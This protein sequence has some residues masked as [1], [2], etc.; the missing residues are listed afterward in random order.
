M[1]HQLILL[2][3]I[4]PLLCLGQ[5]NDI[6]D[7]ISVPQNHDH[8]ATVQFSAR[9]LHLTDIFHLTLSSS[10]HGEGWGTHQFI[11]NFMRVGYIETDA[12]LWMNK[13]LF[14][15]FTIGIGGLYHRLETEERSIKRINT[16]IELIYQPKAEL[17]VLFAAQNFFTS[18]NDL[19]AASMPSMRWR[20]FFRPEPNLN[21]GLTI[22]THSKTNIELLSQCFFRLSDN[23]TVLLYTRAMPLHFGFGIC[24]SIGPHIQIETGSDYH[25]RLGPSPYF[26]IRNDWS[27]RRIS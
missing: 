3:L 4:M 8:N 18:Y 6:R 16:G 13:R 5:V 19:T 14:E 12:Q 26:R 24:K 11:Q 20:L 25:M 2:G 7:F 27:L 15:A 1:R 10:Y 21:F 9:N 17:T 22:S 23:W